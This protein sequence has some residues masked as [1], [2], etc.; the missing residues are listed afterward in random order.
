VIVSVPESVNVALTLIALLSV[1]EPLTVRLL[2]PAVPF[3]LTVFPDPESV[4]VD[5]P[6]VNVPALLS[7]LPE[8]VHEPLV[9]LRVAPVPT[10]TSRKVTVDVEAVSPPV[11]TR[12]S[13][14][15]PV[16]LKPEVVNVPDPDVA[17]VLD[18][19][20]ALDSVIVPEIVRL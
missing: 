6:F 10:V 3:S 19:S 20:V 16:M 12:L 9:K 17:S 11:P 13:V 1:I 14:A 4:I 8:Q 15:P 18:T 5:V 7:Q 2:K